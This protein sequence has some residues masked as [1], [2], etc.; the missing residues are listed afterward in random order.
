LLGDDVDGG[1]PI[2]YLGFNELDFGPA[3]V[4]AAVDAHTMA[5]ADADCSYE[6]FGEMQ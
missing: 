5:A 6:A 4:D 3:L 2:K 1:S